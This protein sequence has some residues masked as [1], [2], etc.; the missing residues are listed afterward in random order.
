MTLDTG[1]HAFFD[2]YYSSPELLKEMLKRQIYTCGTVR[3]NRRNPL[4]SCDKRAVTVIST[5]HET[6]K[7]V[8][9]MTHTGKNVTKTELIFSYTNHIGRVD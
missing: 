7:D 6:T 2:I 4:R 3:S 9:K 5:V 8:N 1:R